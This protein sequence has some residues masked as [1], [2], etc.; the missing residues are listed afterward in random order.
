MASDPLVS[1]EY[2]RGMEAM[3]A[4]SQELSFARTLE[5]IQ[6][7]VRLGAQRL[8][9]ADGITIRLR[10]GDECYTLDGD[11]DSPSPWKG[12]RSKLT[13]SISGWVMLN[14]SS[15]V[16]EDVKT[17]PRIL[18]Y[19]TR[20]SSVVSAV[21]V[22][23]RTSDP[24][25]S[26]GVYWAERRVTTTAEV[27]LLEALSDCTAIALENVKLYNQLEDK[28][29]ERTAALESIQRTE[30][31]LFRVQ[32]QLRQSQKL[33]AI[34]LLAAGIAHDFNNVLTVILSYGILIQSR[35]EDE[36]LKEDV[37]E[38]IAAGQRAAA[39]TKQLLA[40]SK[41]QVLDPQALDVGQ[42]LNGAA[43]LLQK[44][45]PHDIDLVIN[46]APD[47]HAIFADPHQIEQVLL[48][49]T[50]NAR[51]AMPVFGSIVISTLNT[52]VGEHEIPGLP[53]GDYILLTVTDTGVG[54]TDEVRERIFEPFFTTKEMGTGLGLSTVYGIVKQS[55]GHIMA[56]S[57][58]HQGA[59]FSIYLPRHD[60]AI[61]PADYTQG[62]VPGGVE[63]ILVVEVESRVRQV[64][65]RILRRA[66]YTV[67]EAPGAL[68]ALDVLE[69][70]AHP[71]GRGKSDPPSPRITLIVTDCAFPGQSGLALAQHFKGHY[72][73]VRVLWMAGTSPEG[74][75][76]AGFPFLA[77]PLTPTTLLNKVRAVLDS[78]TYGVSVEIKG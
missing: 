24:I 42:V 3:V 34:G 32:E 64:T 67:L 59:T 77:K 7:T 60:G 11:A 47:L 41:Q 29:K 74:L 69:R 10:D 31:A 63:T 75:E 54:M 23:I 50:V 4:I 30:K 14:A 43:K 8:T 26:I 22:P 66:G 13:E 55:G 56:A 57:Q 52:V 62:R 51:D 65:C 39:L 61:Q 73:D 2:V 71:S 68:E 15:L 53:S 5:A 28:I 76:A 9:G 45:L 70:Q 40:F 33:E 25:G 12:L 46:N 17:D 44:L 36:Q 19:A 21:M 35:V 72:P 78:Q 16:I 48:N 37:G 58:P 18:A 27:K 20:P 49:L 38:I 1:D 6:R